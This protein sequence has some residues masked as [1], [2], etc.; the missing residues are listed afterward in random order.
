MKRIIITLLVLSTQVYAGADLLLQKTGIQE[1]TSHQLIA[2][3]EQLKLDDPFLIQFYGQWKAAG[4]LDFDTNRW[5]QLI[6]GGKLK[7]AAHLLTVIEKKA[8]ERF[9][10]LVNGTKLYLY[11]KLNLAN[12]FFAEWTRL[13]SN[14]NFLETEL[15]MAI[16]QLAGADISNWLIQNGIQVSPNQKQQLKSIE[17]KN[18]KLNFAFQAWVSLRTGENCLQWIGKLAATD[19]LRY[20]LA[21][22]VVVAYAKKGKLGDAAKILKEVYEPKLEQSN[23][24]EKISSYYL[25][26]ARLLYQAGAMDAASEYYKLIPEESSQFLQARVEN[27]W[28]ALRKNNMPALKGELASLKL[29]MF[30]EHFMPEVYLVNSIAN[31][32][33]CQF[34]DVKDSFDRFIDDNTKWA[35]KIESNI[36]KENP[37]VIA[38][39]DFYLQIIKNANSSLQKELATLESLAKESIEATV[40]AIGVQKHWK[41]AKQNIAFGLTLAQKKRTNELRRRWSNR[42]QILDSAIRKMRFVK[43]EFISMMRRF[44]H[45]MNPNSDKIRTIKAASKK[46]NL[47][48][49]FDGIIW[50]DE[51]FKMTAEVKSLCL[52]GK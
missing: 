30:Q 43:V 51:L 7:E 29:D 25:L 11:W 28:I 15:G 37:A 21:Q 10:A 24:I 23:N 38:K 42:K 47:E 49:P 50:G 35:K 19:P 44:A 41:M 39:N 26:L 17:D 32:K 45:K 16:D 22:S 34:A 5:A 4:K 46:K 31:L 40:P 36:Q 48:F 18:S 20:Y 2:K 12:S 52:S 3:H 14:T 8:P 6:V 1:Q 33:L 27:T 9:Q 13:S